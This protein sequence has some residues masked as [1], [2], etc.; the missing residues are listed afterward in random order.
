MLQN[1]K[2]T[3]GKSSLQITDSLTKV[4]NHFFLFA[5]GVSE[6]HEIL[7]FVA[8]EYIYL[9][10]VPDITNYPCIECDDCL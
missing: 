5:I 9:C 1:T 4:F 6:L 10:A 3:V 2:H 7:H 8:F